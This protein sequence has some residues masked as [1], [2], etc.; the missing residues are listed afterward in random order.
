KGLSG[1]NI[2]VQKP[3]K[4]DFKASENIIIGNVCFYGAIKGQAF[5]NGIAG[6]R[7]CVRN[8]GI[9]AVVEGLGDHGCEYMT[10]GKVVVLGKTGR[11]F[12]AG[13]SGGIAYIYDVDK[14]F[15]QERCNMEMVELEKPS[16]NDQREL[17]GLIKNHYHHTDSEKA[18]DIL[19]NWDEN[20]PYFIKVI[21]TDY[22]RALEQATNEQQKQ[23]A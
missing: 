23:T 17:F 13:M 19:E 14:K 4:A 3:E 18:F 20:I 10:G 5:I 22:K 7:F 6:E 2:I 9:T 21:P 16:E 11:N 15:E 12:A 8:S 1:A